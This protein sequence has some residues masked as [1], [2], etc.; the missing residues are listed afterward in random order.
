MRTDKAYD[1]ASS[2]LL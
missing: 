2:M 1:V